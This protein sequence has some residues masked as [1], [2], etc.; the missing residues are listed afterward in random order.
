[1]PSLSLFHIW[2]F[3]EAPRALQLR[4]ASS[5]YS[6]VLFIT[7]KLPYERVGKIWVIS[8]M[9]SLLKSLK[10]VKMLS[11]HK[12]WSWEGAKG[13]WGSEPSMSIISETSFFVT[14]LISRFS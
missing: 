7:E 5:Q 6:E 4:R 14:A 13:H 8:V 9:T 10:K 12:Q 1:M 11:W 2:G 3:C